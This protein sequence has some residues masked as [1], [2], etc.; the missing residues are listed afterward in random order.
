MRGTLPADIHIY[1][2]KVDY[3]TT[4]KKQIKLEAG[5]KT[6]YVTTDNNALY[7]I[8]QNGNWQTDLGKSNHFKYEENINA[9]YINLNKK[10]NKKWV[11]QTGLRVENTNANG[12]QLNTGQTFNKNYTQLFP[13]LYIG[14]SANDKNQF[15]VSYGK[16]IESTRLRRFES[17]LF[18]SR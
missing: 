2:A 14:Y 4:L 8:I 3:A 9:A 7:E 1:S 12:K 16:R 13:T 5:I 15:A 10:L 18:F 11:V 17:V 6:S